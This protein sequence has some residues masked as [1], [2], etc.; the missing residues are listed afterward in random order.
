MPD[1]LQ[2]SFSMKND[3]IEFEL[4]ANMRILVIGSINVDF[5]TLVDNLPD[6]GETIFGNSFSIRPGGKGANQAI[7]AKK[8]GADVS[9]IGKVGN[10]ELSNI[11]LKNFLKYNID[12]INIL[13]SEMSTGIANIIIQGEDNKIIVIPGANHDFKIE[14]FNSDILNDYDI[15]L[16]QQEIN[17]DFVFWVIEKC[18]EKKKILILNPTPYSKKLTEAILNKVTYL[19]PNEIEAKQLFGD[20]YL[21]KLKDYPNKVIVTLGDKGT[22]YYDGNKYVETKAKKVEVIDTTG[23]GD[24]FNGAL[25]A[26]LAKNKSLKSAVEFA[27]KAATFAVTK[28][29]AQDATPSID[30]L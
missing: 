5:I 13:H 7:A 30:D 12:T 2:A 23:A 21:N 14:E 26:A 15:V 19:T 11:A 18:Y 10:D 28:L 6:T 29:G 17:L 22:I 1:N 24:V 3:I 8:L 4:E 27:T 16:L 20:D 25:T 9:F